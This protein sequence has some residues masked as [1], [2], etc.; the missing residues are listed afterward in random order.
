MTISW[1]IILPTGHTAAK[2]VKHEVSGQSYK[3][4][5]DRNLRLYSRT[6]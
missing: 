4:L 2:Q 1:Q 3:A 5:Y 6:F